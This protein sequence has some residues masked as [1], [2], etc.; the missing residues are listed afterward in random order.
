MKRLL[1]GF[2]AVAMAFTLAG[3]GTKKAEADKVRVATQPGVYCANML[4]AKVEGYFEQE[5]KGTG[6]TVEYNSFISAIPMNE[7]FAAGSVDIGISGDV[8]L[9]V[10]KANGLPTKIF[11]KTSRNEEMTALIV[12]P[13]SDIIDIASLKGKKVAVIKGT[14]AARLLASALN[15]AGLT[16]N[17]VEIVNLPVTDIANAVASKQVEAGVVWEPNLTSAINQGLAKRL[18][19]GRGGV[20]QN[21]CY[22]FVSEDFAKGNQVILEAFIRAI[23]KANKQI[24]EN[25]KA[26]AEKLKNEIN[27]PTET[28]AELL[29][30]FEFTPAIGNAELEELGRVEKFNIE[31]DLTK[32]TI[33]FNTF[34]DKSALNAVGI[35]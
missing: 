32:N 5:L 2:L 6:I 14:V 3:C 8:A 21:D 1:T 22:F 20:Q 10:A 12:R 11:A 7:A 30:T 33:D 31:N 4:L 19:D 35:R 27:L 29:K 23:E 25:P 13:D 28:L 34:I 17:D 26:A 16:F 15:T 18:F 9:C 24:A